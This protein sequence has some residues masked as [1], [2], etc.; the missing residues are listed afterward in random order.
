MKIG[1][2]NEE[3]GN[4]SDCTEYTRLDGRLGGH[5]LDDNETCI[6]YGLGCKFVQQLGDKLKNQ[7]RISAGLKSLST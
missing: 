6:Y 5:L 4:Y 7:V 3:L 2:V 1:I